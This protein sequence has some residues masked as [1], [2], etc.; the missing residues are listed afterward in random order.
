MGAQESASYNPPPIGRCSLTSTDDKKVYHWKDVDEI[1]TDYDEYDRSQTLAYWI[2]LKNGTKLWIGS[3]NEDMKKLV[4]FNS[5]KC[6][7]KFELMYGDPS[8]IV[9]VAKNKGEK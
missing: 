8:P 3:P 2:K 7:C 4:K 9:K 6:G 1:Q 5:E